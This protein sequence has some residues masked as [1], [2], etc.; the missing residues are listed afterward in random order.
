MFDGHL[1]SNLFPKILRSLY[2]TITVTKRK[3]IFCLPKLIPK[4]LSKL[5]SNIIKFIWLMHKF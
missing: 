3:K 1:Q 5:I 2:H 4:R